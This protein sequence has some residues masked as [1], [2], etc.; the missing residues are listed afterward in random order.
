MKR[1]LLLTINAIAL[2]SA[3]HAQITKGTTFLGGGIGY[4]SY[5]SDLSTNTS[6]KEQ[7]LH[8]SPSIGK[9]IKE[10]RV[11]GIFLRYA[12]QSSE[13]K[14]P[15]EPIKPYYNNYGAGFFLREYFPLNKN[16]YLYGEPSIAL[17]YNKEKQHYSTTDPTIYKG[18]NAGISLATGLTCALS[19][20]FHLEAGLPGLAGISYGRSKSKNNTV[21]GKYSSFGFYSSLSGAT[22]FSIGFRFILPK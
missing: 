12:H 10:N 16:F 15:Q 18:W 8:V 11:A 17:G 22:D 20:K 9:A 5:K 6:T 14:M 7:S 21:E 3:S 4:N 13:V 1:F 2:A 19:K